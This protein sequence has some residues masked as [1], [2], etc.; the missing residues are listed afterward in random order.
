MT[1]DKIPE[2]LKSRAQ[3][4][5]WRIVQRSG[6]KTKIPMQP[7]G[8]AAS[9]TDPKTWS[10]F[11][12][13]GPGLI[14][15]VFSPD[16]PFI[17]IDLDGCRNPKTGK[18]D[19]W[20]RDVVVRMNTYTEISPSKTGV[21]MFGTTNEI[22]KH[23]NKIEIDGAGHGGKKPGIEVYDCGRY[24]AIT[25][26]R[27]KVNES[28]RCV[29]DALPW[30]VEAHKMNQTIYQIDGSEVRNESPVAERAAK[31]VAKM[32]PSI[33]GSRGHD[34]AYKVACV[35]MLGFELPFSDA[36]AIMAR[37]F[38][39]RCDPPWTEKELTHKLNSASKQPGQRG[40]LRDANTSDWSKIFVRTG[41]TPEELEPE[42]E[43]VSRT[44]LESAA[45][46]YLEQLMDGHEYLVD[47]GIPDLDYALG[48][49]VAPGEMVIIAARPSH[50]KSAISLQIVHHM[51]SNGI[52]AVIV[53]EEMSALAIGKRT[54]QFITEINEENWKQREDDVMSSLMQHFDHRA[55]TIILESC[56]TVERVVSEVE[57]AVEEIQAGVVVIDY[58][59]LLASKGASRY[60]QVTHA[61]QEMRR[62]A[63]RLGVVVIVLAQLNRNIESRAS[64]V[65]QSS[66]LKETGQLEQDA[67]VIIFGVWPSRTNPEVEKSKYHL[68]VSKNRN[69]AINKG[70]VDLNFN[71]ARQKLVEDASMSKVED[72]DNYEHEFSDWHK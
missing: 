72:H 45:L 61:S 56:G 3:W 26:E 23:K 47:T 6:K 20:A 59:Q 63:S 18:L 2:E 10:S 4:V 58:V 35:L 42:P 9:S 65:P 68:Y 22:W 53:S 36:L 19:D 14:G 48:G 40:Y 21:K 28:I 29:D 66:D 15:F 12:L 16:D 71:A 13:L 1:R 55:K 69:R 33:S 44:S 24:F 30:L 49:G 67:D 50:G 8:Y 41:P 60:D 7:N 11:D 54:I 52:P 62:M 64:F 38:N 70:I 34:A 39:N 17:G 27:I 43:A 31:Y 32:E 57:K 5:N 51:T 25:G 37:E 46:L